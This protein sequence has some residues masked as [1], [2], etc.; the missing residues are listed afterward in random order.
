MAAR[1]LILAGAVTALGAL[2]GVILVSPPPDGPTLPIP[3]TDADSQLDPVAQWEAATQ[4]PVPPSV[5]RTFV[6]RSGDNLAS[7]LRKAG[8]DRAQAYAAVRSLRGIYDPRRD[9]KI[10][11]AL[12]ISLATVNG[13][14]TNGSNLAEFLLPVAYNRDVVVRPTAGGKFVATQVVKAL[15]REL[16]HINGAISTSLFQDGRAAG[17]SIPVIA[18]LIRIYSF[19]V[20]FQRELQKGDRFELVFERFFGTRSSRMAV[21][22]TRIS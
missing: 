9:F 11:D 10:G 16:V 4:L 21:R 19:S 22:S 20:D 15:E 5:A 13:H 1:P 18:E 3:T 6:V 17:I 14:S 2:I 12:K 8:V 7:V